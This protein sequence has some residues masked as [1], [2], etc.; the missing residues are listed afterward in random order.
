MGF[1]VYVKRK[2]AHIC[3]GILFVLL[4]YFNLFYLE[5]MGF[6]ILFTVITPILY[7]KTN[8]K[9]INWFMRNFEREENLKKFPAGGVFFYGLGCFIVSLFFSKEIAIASILVLTVGDSVSDLIGRNGNLKSRINYEKNLEGFCA[10]VILSSL[11]AGIFVPFQFALLAATIAM[12]FE[13][14]DLKIGKFK[15]DDNLIIPI[16]SALVLFIFL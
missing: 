15:I 14:I 16:I 11:A 12:L 1:P 10:G 8:F 9:M 2:I 6:I 4:V 3:A 7:R 5:V 13:Y